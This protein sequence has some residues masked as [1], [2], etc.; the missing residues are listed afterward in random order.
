MTD[1]TDISDR[2]SIA[3]TNNDDS[4]ETVD[5]D[6]PASVGIDTAG[7][8]GLADRIRSL[9]YEANIDP[10]MLSF[11]CMLAPQED[12]H[13]R[14]YVTDNDEMVRYYIESGD[15]IVT[16]D[17]V[18]KEIVAGINQRELEVDEMYI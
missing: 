15:L 5:L 17:R 2:A 6:A 11:P 4:V 16:R 8:A 12:E 9:A 3:H 1:L 10:N 7:E 14:K 13:G 18:E